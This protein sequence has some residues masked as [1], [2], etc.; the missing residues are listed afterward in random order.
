MIIFSFDFLFGSSLKSLSLSTKG[1]TVWLKLGIDLRKQAIKPKKL[2][3]WEM[4]AGL[5][6]IFDTSASVFV[7]STVFYCAEINLP[8]HEISRL[9]KLH[10]DGLILIPCFLSRCS[11]SLMWLRC[12]SK[13]FQK[14]KRL[15]DMELQ[16]FPGNPL[17]NVS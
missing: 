7:G 8:R 15:S 11:T 3:N 5:F 17:G 10:L 13:V 12:S 16:I 14:I 4:L 2:L 6:L 9:N 1:L